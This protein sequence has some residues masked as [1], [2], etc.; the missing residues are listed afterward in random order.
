MI[1]DAHTHIGFNDLINKKPAELVESMKLAGIDKAMVYAGEIDN[2]STEKLLE[3]L[4]P[5]KDIL[6]P[7]G[8]ISPL[9]ES[10]PSVEKVES[11]L[12]NKEIFGL[13]FYPAYEPFYPYNEELKPYLKLLSKYQKPAIFHSG[14]TYNITKGA[15]VKY[16]HPLHIDETAVDFPDLKIIIAHLGYPWIIDAA[17]VAYKNKNVYVDCSGL[18]YDNPDEK[19]KNLFKKLITTFIEYAEDSN[20][21][22]FGT[23]WPISNQSDYVKI[24]KELP[25]PEDALDDMLFKEASRIFNI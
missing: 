9:S 15:R 7:V 22:I 5:F 10:K 24:V 25:L 4:K 12:K 3:E 21:L 8:S 14:D 20:K 19:D 17:E 2:C 11:W 23:D 1:I 13:K 6:F 18:F 16:S